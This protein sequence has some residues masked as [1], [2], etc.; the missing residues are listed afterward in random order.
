M[1]GFC[2]MVHA[3]EKGMVSCT[4]TWK[5]DKEGKLPAYDFLWSQYHKTGGNT[6]L[7]YLFLQCYNDSPVTVHV[8][9]F[10]EVAR[11]FRAECAKIPKFEGSVKSVYGKGNFRRIAG[12]RRC[13]MSAKLARLTARVPLA[14]LNGE[15]ELWE[16][17]GWFLCSSRSNWLT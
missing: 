3:S 10:C 15:E 7:V 8:L 4:S 12:A 2:Q 5:P 16:K 1:T 13:M 17:T 11:C 6:R 9:L 14:F